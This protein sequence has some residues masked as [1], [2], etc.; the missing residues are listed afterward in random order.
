MNLY[1][2]DLH[3]HCGISYGFGSL[4]NALH[5]AEKHLDFCCITG[6]AMWPDIYKR[7]PE[8]A[9][10]VDFHR[11]GFQKLYDHWD[12]VR[13]TVNR[14]NGENLVTFQSYE[15]HSSKWGDHHFV[16]PDPE[17]P[18]IYH[19]SPAEIIENCGCRAIAVPHHIGYTPGYRGIDWDG[20][21][22]SISPVVEVYS[23]HGCSMRADGPFPY[24]HDMGPLDPHNTVAEG[25]KRGLR[26]SFVGST[27]HHA[28]FPG[29]YGD[30]LAGVWA[31]EKTRESLFEA[32]RKGHTYAVTGDRISCRM[33]LGDAF[34]GDTVTADRRTVEITAEGDAPLAAILL[35]KN[36]R[37]V[38]SRIFDAA[39]A[40]IA[41]T[42]SLATGQRCKLRLEMGW[43]SSEELYHWDG[44][45]SVTDGE[46]LRVQP[47]WRG[48]N[49]LS[50]SY[51]KANM[52]DQ[53]NALDNSCCFDKQSAHFSCDTLRNP[54][55]LH[56]QTSAF[57]FEVKGDDHTV[58]TLDLGGFHHVI[59]L[60]RLLQYG[61]TGHV[62]PW[63]SHAYQMHTAYTA[64]ACAGTL[65]Y[66]D[67]PELDQDVYQAEV[68][69]VNGCR[70]FLSPVYARRT[71]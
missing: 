68:I 60:S 42:S 49:A 32:I 3:N 20:F 59:P 64:E 57:V 44:C 51:K 38:C 52:A 71:E 7:T 28:G 18:L 33:R 63:H 50:P 47:Y 12:T 34:M 30:G 4:E 61:F 8:T 24:Y 9:F 25:L 13:E 5:I 21:D 36:G 26:F 6:H 70:A 66:T 19:D 58:I 31:E 53:T 67:M 35:R 55:A 14:Y 56:P 10:V 16:S 43:S 46:L 22:P 45:L 40:S 65:T 69:Q 39:A 11:Q 17:F 62:K 27:D 1:W 41:A 37:I 23:K 15:M 2:G 29:S 54:T 48:R